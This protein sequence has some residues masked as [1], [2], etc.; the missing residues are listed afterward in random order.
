VAMLVKLFMLVRTKY[1]DYDDLKQET[2][3]MG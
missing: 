3:V 2:Y 1:I